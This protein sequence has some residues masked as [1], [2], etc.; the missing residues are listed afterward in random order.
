MASSDGWL[1]SVGGRWRIGAN[2]RFRPIPAISDLTYNWPVDTVI[3]VG[4]ATVLLILAEVFFHPIRAGT[5]RE[6]LFGF[7]AKIVF[8]S[9]LTGWLLMWLTEE[10]IWS[11]APR[12]CD[13]FA[14]IELKGQVYRNCSYLVH[15]YEAGEWLFWGGFAA[16]AILSIFGRIAERP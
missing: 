13:S 6:K 3:L 16:I 1:R 15:R 5:R 9:M 12:A 14:S 11:P 10:K 8:V 7:L 4:A 2:V